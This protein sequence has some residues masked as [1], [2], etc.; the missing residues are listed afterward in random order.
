MQDE[1]LLWLEEVEGTEALNWV[2]QQN[3]RSQ[4]KL[5]KIP[6]FDE[7]QTEILSVLENDQKIPYGH[8][9]NGEYYNFWQDKNHLKGIWRKCSYSDFIKGSPDWQPLLDMD[10]LNQQENK[11]WLLSDIELYGPHYQRALLKLS[12]GGSDAA[13]LREFDLQTRQFVSDGFTLPEAKTSATWVD[14]DRILVAS[15]FSQSALTDSGYPS[16]LRLWQRGTDINDAQALLSVETDEMGLFTFRLEHGEQ[17]ISGVTRCLDF[18][19]Y[20][21]YIYVNNQLVKLPIPEKST[22]MGLFNNQLLVQL[23][24]DWQ[25]FKQGD[26][27]SFAIDPLIQAETNATLVFRPN[28]QSAIENVQCSADYLFIELLQNVSSSILA[29]DAQWQVTDITPQANISISIIDCLHQQN[30]LLVKAEGF[31][32]PESLYLLDIKAPAT[33]LAQLAPQFDD[34][35]YQVQQQWITS[36]DGTRVPYY[37]IAAKNIKLDGKNPCILY[38]YGGFEI[39]LKP[40]YLATQGKTWLEKGGVYVIANIRGGGEFGPAWH[41]A[42]LK[43]HRWK[44]YQDFFAVAEHLIE[45][46]VT[47]PNYL[48]AMGGSNGGL[49]MGVCLT[50]RPDLFNAIDI[51]VPLLDMQRF[52]LLLAGASWMAEYG[53]PDIDADWQVIK[54]YSPLQNLQADKQYPKVLFRT[55]TKDDRVHPAHARKLAAKMEAYQH[56]FYYYENTQGGHAGAADL[57]QRAYASALDYSYFWQQLVQNNLLHTETLKEQQ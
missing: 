33:L 57:K 22:M 21:T 27:I 2:N 10:N 34:N 18:F 37:L 51:L 32:L 49:L 24:T 14:N 5:E 55:S 19:S 44:A 41:Q 15:E 11:D 43:H 20:Q 28:A 35:K 30:Q 53:S 23:K 48:G 56:D 12:P 50:Q 4:Q 38:G 1:D 9:Y 6:V 31:V 3:K 54:T 36:D 46:N 16:Q 26:L 29:L 47:S 52:H 8:C 25:A 39:S 42:A 17:S 45:T 13:E 40:H 7:F